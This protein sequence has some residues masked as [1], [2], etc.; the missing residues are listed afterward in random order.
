MRKSPPTTSQRHP[1]VASAAWGWRLEII[2]AALGL[3][4]LIIAGEL[5]PAAPIAVAVV[6][7]IVLW[8]SPQ[9][10]HGL[11]RRIDLNHN[12]AV[13]ERALWH[14]GVVGRH[15]DIPRVAKIASLPVG[16]RYLVRVPIGLHCEAIEARSAEIAVALGAREVL[17]KPLPQAAHYVEIATIFRNAFPQLLRSPLVNRLGSTGGSNT[18]LLQ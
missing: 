17:V 8:Q 2:I 14:C 5:N 18:C 9:T 16:V 4:A 6:V 1:W 12:V 11:Q 7:G 15:G 10:R 3:L 13:L